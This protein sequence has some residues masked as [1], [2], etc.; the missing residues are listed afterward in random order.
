M[1][2][3]QGRR[4][5]PVILALPVAQPVH[6]GK[7]ALALDLCL[8]AP[9]TARQPEQQSGQKQH[10]AKAD[11]GFERLNHHSD[12]RNPPNHLALELLIHN[13]SVGRI[14]RVSLCYNLLP[15][16]LHHAVDDQF[17]LALVHHHVPHRIAV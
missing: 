5:A 2:Y 4:P 10:G 17:P 16:Q 11:R 14:V 8:L 3:R 1:T 13:R 12:F 6:L 15:V 9:R 7:N